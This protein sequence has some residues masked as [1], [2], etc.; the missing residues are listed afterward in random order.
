MHGITSDGTT[1]SSSIVKPRTPLDNLDFG[2]IS[3]VLR[4]K[5]AYAACGTT[6]TTTKSVL[7]LRQQHEHSTLQPCIDALM[8][9]CESPNRY[10]FEKQGISSQCELPVIF[11]NNSF[12]ATTDK[13]VLSPTEI[14]NRKVCDV[15]HKSGSPKLSRNLWL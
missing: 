13:H 11:G 4:K 7:T 10:I 8:T 15:T 3:Q 5:D 2:E 14:G 6:T 9:Q 12:S 1:V